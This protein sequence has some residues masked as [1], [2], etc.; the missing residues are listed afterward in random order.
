MSDKNG[1]LKTISLDGVEYVRKDS[2]PPASPIMGPVRIIVADKGFVFVGNCEELPG[3]RVRITN[4][5]NIR[6]WGTSKGLG[7]LI[8]GPTPTTK[9]DYY[10]TVECD[11]IAAIA[12]VSGW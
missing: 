10:G 9:A 1:G 12:V 3:N 7:E 8:T 5:R 6:Y 11:V 4:C 2:I